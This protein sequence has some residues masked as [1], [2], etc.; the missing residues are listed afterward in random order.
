MTRALALACALALTTGCA[1]R[2]ATRI[3]LTEAAADR[4]LARGQSDAVEGIVKS[5]DANAITVEVDGQLEPIPRIDV[6]HVDQSVT[7]RAITAG[8]VATAIGAVMTIGG[9]LVFEC[10]DNEIPFFCPFTSKRNTLA[11]LAFLGGIGLAGIGLTAWI[12][13]SM[14]HGRVDR[15]LAPTIVTGRESGPGVGVLVR[16]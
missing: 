1:K 9:A 5:A 4:R 15:I 7:E 13:G 6:A 2:Y 11:G 12:G 3:E 14:E 16:Y 8:K 10:N